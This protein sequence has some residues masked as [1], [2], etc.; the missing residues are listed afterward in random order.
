MKKIVVVSLGLVLLAL[1]VA[2]VFGFVFLGSVVKA[3]VEKVGP[4]VTQVPVKLDSANLSIFSGKGSL[5]GFELGNP[6]GFKAPNAIKVGSVGVA[7]VPK[8]VFGDKVIIQSIR[9]EIG[10]AH[11]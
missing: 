8:S 10:R 7:V 1:L 5:H 9:V 11:V 2:F 3:G 4:I 6:Q